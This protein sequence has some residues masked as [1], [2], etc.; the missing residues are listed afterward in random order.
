MI[1]DSRTGWSC[2]YRLLAYWAMTM[3]LIVAWTPEPNPM[4]DVA[5]DRRIAMGKMSSLLAGNIVF[6]GLSP[7]RASADTNS[8]AISTESPFVAYNILP[9]SSASFD[10]KL[11]KVDVSVL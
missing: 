8:N 6:S 4:R 5:M 9:D 3:P 2:T 11:V 1:M 10:P 7:E